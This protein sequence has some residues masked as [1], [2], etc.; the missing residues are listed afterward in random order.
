LAVI[1]SSCSLSL[2]EQYIISIHIYKER[3]WIH[4]VIYQDPFFS[5]GKHLPAQAKSAPFKVS[6]I[7]DATVVEIR[8]RLIGTDR[9]N[10]DGNNVRCIRFHNASINV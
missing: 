9:S 8:C 7:H 1:C 4:C 3:D 2:C 5:F 10:D 6:I